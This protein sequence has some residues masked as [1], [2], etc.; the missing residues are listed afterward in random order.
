MK[1]LIVDDEPLPRAELRRMLG[2]FHGIE[3]VGEA[4]DANQALD[5]IELLGPDLVF[6]DVQMPEKSGF[7]LLTSLTDPPHVRRQSRLFRL[8]VSLSKQPRAG[9]RRPLFFLGGD[10]R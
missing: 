9:T 4:S 6:L 8:Q 7:E 10:P 5:L 2:A 3:I 1:T